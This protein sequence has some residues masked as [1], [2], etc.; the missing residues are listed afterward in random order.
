MN[1]LS[2]LPN[3]GEKLEE[4]LIQVGIRNIDELKNTGTE[5]AFI[6]LK[7]IDEN[8]CINTLYALEGAIQKIRWHKLPKNRKIQLLD[9]YNSLK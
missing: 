8:V 4:K 6:R 2:D 9:F 3:I 7:T 1:E 5:N